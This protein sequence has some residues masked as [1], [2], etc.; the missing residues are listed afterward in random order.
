LS[1]RTPLSPEGQSGAAFALRVGA[2]SDDVL[3]QNRVATANLDEG[4]LRSW[5]DRAAAKASGYELVRWD[6]RCPDD[7]VDDFAYLQTLMNAAPGSHPDDAVKTTA[8]D[9]R[10]A[11]ARWLPLGAYW[12]VAARHRQTGALVGLTELQLP[13]GRRWRADQGD[14]V[15]DTA[16]RG[17][18]LGRW[19][20]ASTALRLMSERPDV[21]FI[22]T[23][24]AGG[25][26]PMLAINRAMG[27]RPACLWRRW[28]LHV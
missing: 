17:L 1:W 22:E 12:R 10:T 15:V 9:V 16:H 26:E 19:L 23:W 8:S 28:D 13:D 14:T 3:E 18:G 11:E 21:R 5:V 7:L 2:A 27:F 20:K 6:G 24:N 4:L 25:N